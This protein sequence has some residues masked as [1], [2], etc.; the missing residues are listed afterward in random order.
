MLCPPDNKAHFSYSVIECCAQFTEWALE[1][2]AQNVRFNVPSILRVF[3]IFR[4]FNVVA[5][6]SHGVY[7]LS[8][9]TFLDRVRHAEKKQQVT[10][11]PVGH[12]SKLFF[13]A[14]PAVFIQEKP[15]G[16]GWHHTNRLRFA[17]L[18]KPTGSLRY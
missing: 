16:I 3:W 4:I 6:P 11:T 18:K 17:A 9:V 15:E 14:L 5:V 1:H 10:A 13:K 2:S 12:N 7:Q 8:L